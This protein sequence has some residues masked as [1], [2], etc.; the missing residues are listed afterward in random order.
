[1]DEELKCPVCRR[2]YTKPVLLPCSHSM[3]VACALSL[4]EP[5]SNHLPQTTLEDGTPVPSDQISLLDFPDIDKL[6]IV[7]ETDSGVVCNSRPSS[8]V[9][10]PSVANIFLQS[11]QSCSWA[12]RCCVCQRLV[13]LEENGALSLPTNRALETIVE[14]YQN[15]KKVDSKCDKCTDQGHVAVTATSMCAQCEIF[16]CDACRDAHHPAKGALTKHNLVD[17]TQGNMMRKRKAA[18]DLKC[19]EHPT[20]LLAMYCI[21]CRLPVCNLCLRRSPHE[22]R[23]AAP[24]LHGQESEGKTLS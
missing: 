15:R 6:S 24:G 14:K 20:E 19:H 22:P 8:Y 1:M 4:Q 10:T 18:K 2:T 17:P 5:A 23:G 12:I 9:G 13:F 16:Y 21:S 7:S 11:L 3:C